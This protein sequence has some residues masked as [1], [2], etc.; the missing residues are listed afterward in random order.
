[1]IADTES[2][3]CAS[4]IGQV[5]RR[6]ISR[7]T[8][9]LVGF[10]FSL[11]GFASAATPEKS[12]VLRWSAGTPGSQFSAN[13]DGTYRYGLAGNDFSITLAVDSQ[14]LDKARRRIEPLLAVFLTLRSS[15]QFLELDARNITLE[16]VDHFHDRHCALNP[17]DLASRLKFSSAEFSEKTAREIAQHPNKKAELAAASAEHTEAVRAMVEFLSLKALRS[18]PANSGRRELTGWI[19]FTTRSKWVAEL[20]Q[21]ENFVLRVPIGDLR[22]E[23]PFTLPPSQADINLRERPNN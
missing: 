18:A 7:P 4:Y 1:V 9:L 14:E 21:Q 11:S 23:F 5:I 12:H 10:L 22:V 3:R 6:C 17:D 8:L 2:R 19:F 16:F 20:S 15:R 13:S